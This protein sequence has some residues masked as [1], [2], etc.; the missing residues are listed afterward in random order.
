VKIAMITSFPVTRN[1]LL[2]YKSWTTSYGGLDI[3]K[4]GGLD[5]HAYTHMYNYI[6]TQPKELIQQGINM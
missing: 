4:S 2:H 1:W 5:S 3:R 6:H